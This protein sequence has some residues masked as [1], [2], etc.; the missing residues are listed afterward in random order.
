MQLELAMAV[1]IGHIFPLFAN[2][3][4]GKG[5]ATLLGIG[6]AIQPLAAVIAVG[7]FLLVYLVTHY[8]SLG[9][10]FAAMSFP[11]SVI[12]VFPSP[13]SSMVVFS[14]FV[15][16]AALLTHQKNIERIL[17]KQEKKMKPLTKKKKVQPQE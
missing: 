15:A 8:V 5:I 10:V 4:G 9:S 12:I 11:V 1:L 6:L 16:M 3:R 13:H 2:F 14:L 7:V 17:R